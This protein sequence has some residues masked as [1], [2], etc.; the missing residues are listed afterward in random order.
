M[1]WVVIYCYVG[2][3]NGEAFGVEEVQTLECVDGELAVHTWRI[4]HIRDN[5]GDSVMACFSDNCISHSYSKETIHH[6]LHDAGGCAV[7]LSG[8]IYSVCL[9]SLLAN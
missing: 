1:T 5:A 8:M 2:L 4:K 6:R 3:C 7:M 9:L